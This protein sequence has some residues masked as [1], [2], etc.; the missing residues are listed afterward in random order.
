MLSLLNSEKF[1]TEYKNYKEKIENLTNENLK[2]ECSLLL[3]KLVSEVKSIDTLHE[4]L[5]RTNSLP[6]MTSNTRDALVNI[7]KQ[8]NKKLSENTR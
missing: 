3:S 1:Q 8:L 2:K 5:Y 7:R 4:E 6:T